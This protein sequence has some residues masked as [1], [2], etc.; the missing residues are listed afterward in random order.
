MF[1]F[2]RLDHSRPTAWMMMTP[3]IGNCTW[4]FMSMLVLVFGIAF[5]SA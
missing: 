4:A 5:E 3:E 2:H 1:E